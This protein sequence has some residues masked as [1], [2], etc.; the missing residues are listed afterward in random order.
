MSSTRETGLQ[1]W[2]LMPSSLGNLSFES[3]RQHRLRRC[4]GLFPADGLKPAVFLGKI[5]FFRLTCISETSFRISE[6]CFVMRDLAGRDFET[7]SRRG[8]RR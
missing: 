8:D 6:I 7:G 3:D 5:G 1:F 2:R 4:D